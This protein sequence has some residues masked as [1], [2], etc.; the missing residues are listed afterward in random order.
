MTAGPHPLS[1]DVSAQIRRGAVDQLTRNL[2]KA[3]ADLSH[4]VATHKAIGTEVALVAGARA[5]RRTGRLQHSVRATASTRGAKIRA[6]GAQVPYAGPI[7]WG[8]P[9]RHRDGT[10]RGGPIAPNPFVYDTLAQLGRWIVGQYAELVH[11][12]AREVDPS[13]RIDRR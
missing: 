6:G 8:W 5:P 13:A 3:G 10:H 4:V 2:R 9:T 1:V 7:H 11:R 12:A